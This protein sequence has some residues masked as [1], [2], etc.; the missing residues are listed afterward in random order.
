MALTSVTTWPVCDGGGGGVEGSC[1][2]CLL[3]VGAECRR[4]KKYYQRD[5]IYSL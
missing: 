5:L 2:L 1:G 3:Q 4:Q